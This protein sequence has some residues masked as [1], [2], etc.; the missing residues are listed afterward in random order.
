MRQWR[1]Q[2]GSTPVQDHLPWIRPHEFARYYVGSLEKAKC[3]NGYLWTK[4]CRRPGGSLCRGL[5]SR[6][7]VNPPRERIFNVPGVV[8]ALIALLLGIHLFAAYLLT[9]AQTNELLALFAFSPLRYA[10]VAPPWLPNWWG[11]QIWTFVTYAFLHA[12]LGH[13]FFNF[14]WLLA[15]GPPIARRFGARRFLVFCAA[16]AAAGALAHLVMHIGEFAP[17]IGAS[18]AISGMMAAAMRFVFQRGGPLGLL[19][20]G[21]QESY[22][23]PAASLAV[24]LRDPRILAFLAVWFGVNIIFGMGAVSMPGTEGSVAW[25]AH[26]GGFLAGLLGFSLFD[27]VRPA[28]PDTEPEPSTI[29][30]DDDPIRRQ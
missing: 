17:M 6:P 25:E 16:T 22:Q 3:R 5:H 2:V 28:A 10:E 18:A 30:T 15:F 7:L 14:V 21:E 26:I 13:L 20:R 19:G 11:P 23:V 29:T 8:V 12:D 1:R 27:P 24:M 9:I 4:A